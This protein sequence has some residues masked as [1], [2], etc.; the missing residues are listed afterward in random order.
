MTMMNPE[1]T[2]PE[3]DVEDPIIEET[4]EPEIPPHAP[5]FDYFM[6][7]NNKTW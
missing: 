3:E 6:Q 1:N 7:P 5:T 4:S 2:P